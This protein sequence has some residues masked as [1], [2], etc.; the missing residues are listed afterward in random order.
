M[1]GALWVKF[2]PDV[3]N[4]FVLICGSVLY[5]KMSIQNPKLS[6]LGLYFNIWNYLYY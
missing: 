5:C 2:Q 3:L 1:Y 4:P 6:S